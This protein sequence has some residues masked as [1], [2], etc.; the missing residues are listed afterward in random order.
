MVTKQLTPSISIRRRRDRELRHAIS[1][2][3]YFFSILNA[4]HLNTASQG[5]IGK[6]RLADSLGVKAVNPTESI[7][8]TSDGKVPL[9]FETDSDGTVLVCDLNNNKMDKTKLADRVTHTV[10][11][12]QTRFDL[13]LPEAG[14]YAV[15]V[16]AQSKDDPQQL[17]HVHTYL[18]K[19][20]QPSDGKA[21][22]DFGTCFHSF[23]F[24]Y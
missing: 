4:I 15:N 18:V 1:R 13:D 19:S 6:S 2:H 5:I 3:F 17:H 11:G 14:E 9:L 24:V 20:T 21:S 10:D 22:S 23:I 16:Y 7:I 8:N 12:N